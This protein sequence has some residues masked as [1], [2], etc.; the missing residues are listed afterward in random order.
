MNTEA[1]ERKLAACNNLKG[2]LQPPRLQNQ[3]WEGGWVIRVQKLGGGDGA[4]G[5]YCRKGHCLA[6][7]TA[8]GQGRR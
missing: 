3:N 2:Q 8:W 1:F 4:T 7:L 6:E 5:L